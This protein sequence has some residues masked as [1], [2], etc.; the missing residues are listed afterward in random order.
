MGNRRDTI[1]QQATF[2]APDLR[3]AAKEWAQNN[4][5]IFLKVCHCFGRA[6]TAFL[7]QKALLARPKQCW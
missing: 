1:V 5:P 3:P 4:F 7:P 2:D 6:Q